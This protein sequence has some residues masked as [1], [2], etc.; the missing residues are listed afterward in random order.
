MGPVCYTPLRGTL[1]VNT[2][3]RKHLLMNCR[4]GL[5]NEILASIHGFLSSLAGGSLFVAWDFPLCAALKI[6]YLISLIP[7]R[8]SKIVVA[9]GLRAWSNTLKQ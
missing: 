8:V 9:T 7:S 6:G 5:P 3:Y 4:A 1:K 2:P